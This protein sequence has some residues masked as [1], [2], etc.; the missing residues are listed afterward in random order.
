MS[1]P[2]HVS[3]PRQQKHFNYLSLH[4]SCS[5][6]SLLPV[7]DI[8]LTAWWCVEGVSLLTPPPSSQFDRL[9]SCQSDP[10]VDHLHRTSSDLAPRK[11][12]SLPQH[13][14]LGVPLYPL[15]CEPQGSD[16]T[17]L[18]R[19]TTPEPSTVVSDEE[20]F[21]S[22]RFRQICVRGSPGLFSY[23][24]YGSCSVL[25]QSDS[26]CDGNDGSLEDGTGNTGG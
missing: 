15:G 22:P 14:L 21:R 18:L 23:Y 1:Q 19:R 4:Y 24:S 9:E 10:L 3:L 25:L 16:V 6:L 13:S 11:S 7:L 17:R 8:Q 12:L 20:L 2:Y 26:R 5:L